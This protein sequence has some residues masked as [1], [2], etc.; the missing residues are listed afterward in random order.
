MQYNINH[1]NINTHFSRGKD[2]KC[3][4]PIKATL[5]KPN[6]Q[7]TSDTKPA[8]TDDEQSTI[9]PYND[10]CDDQ[11]AQD[12]DTSFSNNNQDPELPTPSL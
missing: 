5:P 2:I 9:L 10:T 4:H 7:F 6:V 1:G 12:E 8:T 11:T 3:T